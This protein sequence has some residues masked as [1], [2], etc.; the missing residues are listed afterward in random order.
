MRNSDLQL[1]LSNPKEWGSQEFY[2]QTQIVNLN[3]YTYQGIYNDA[4]LIHKTQFSPD[5]PNVPSLVTLAKELNGSDNYLSDKAFQS[6]KS[7]QNYYAGLQLQAISLIS[8]LASPSDY[9]FPQPPVHA[10]SPAGVRNDANLNLETVSNNISAELVS[11]PYPLLDKT[12][13]LD[14]HNN[15]LFQNA[16]VL[17]STGGTTYN[18]ALNLASGGLKGWTIAD[19]N[20]IS[21]LFDQVSGAPSSYSQALSGFGFN[22]KPGPVTYSEQY[23]DKNSHWYSMGTKTATNNGFLTITQTSPG[24]Y[25]VGWIDDSGKTGAI[26][27]FSGTDIAGNLDSD[28][29]VYIGKQ[30]ENIDAGWF[31]YYGG[32]IN[33]PCIIMFVKDSGGDGPFAF[34][35]QSFA[36]VAL[37]YYNGFNISLDRSQYVDMQSQSLTQQLYAIPKFTVWVP[38][39][40]SNYRLCNTVYW[41]SSDPV[42]API[43]NVPPWPVS[44]SNPEPVVQ[45]TTPQTNS[46]VIHWMKGAS[47]HAVTFTASRTLPDGTVVSGSTILTGPDISLIQILGQPY[48][49]VDAIDVYPSM[50]SIY[51]DNFMNTGVQLYVTRHNLFGRFE[52]VSGAVAYSSSDSRVS[53][54]AGGRVKASSIIP[55]GT[56][57]DITATDNSGNMEWTQSIN[58]RKSVTCTINVQ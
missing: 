47:G 56:E 15:N 21:A 30:F 3:Q 5:D 11:M 18:Y 28:R 8:A 2:I 7:Q 38:G 44:S 53:V 20:S 17:N 22:L 12:Q 39:N 46:G 48:T 23:Q 45:F 49:P 6:L 43:S 31:Y 42:N 35:S 29:D 14:I 27:T 16:S 50:Y 34:Q 13:A 51:G 41:T 36:P 32:H 24:N 25:T 58:K 26:G 55:P 9:I 54:S 52:D 10:N 37:G 19:T 4:I 1:F 33:G 57:V 40:D